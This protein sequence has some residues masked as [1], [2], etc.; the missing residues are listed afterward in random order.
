MAKIRGI[1]LLSFGFAWF[2]F[3]GCLVVAG[4][5][6]LVLMEQIEARYSRCSRRNFAMRR[7][8]V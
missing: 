1:L 2:C 7:K 3:H 5:L 4:W 8:Y 6:V